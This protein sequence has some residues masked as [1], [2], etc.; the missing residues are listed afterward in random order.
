MRKS[1]IIFL[2][3]FMFILIVYISGCRHAGE[4][5]VKKNV[6]E[7]SDFIVMLMGSFPERVLEVNDAWKKGLADNLILIEEHMGPFMQ[8]ESQG[9]NVLSTCEQAVASLISLGIPEESI[10]V[11][12]GSARSTLDEALI[13]KSFLSEK[14]DADTLLLISSPTH[15][16]RA[17]MIF[18]KVLHDH[19]SPVFIGC[20]PSSYSSFRETK[21]WRRKEDIQLVLAE[22]VKVGSFL[23][24]EKRALTDEEQMKNKRSKN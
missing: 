1:V 16:R 18:R 21:W 19:E 7:H 24:F 13:I 11:L 12:P 15:M 10:T 20:Q 2:A 4:W 14:K 3:V 8:L 5:L 23:V 9:I 17:F 6:P 22:F